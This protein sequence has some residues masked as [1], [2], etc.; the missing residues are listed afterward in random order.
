MKNLRD[1]LY[2]AGIEQVIGSTDLNIGNICNN[3]SS[4]SPGSLFVAIKGYKSDGHAFISEAIGRGAFAIVCS[5]LPDKIESK[6]TYVQVK[7]TNIALGIISS[8]F[9]DN[10]SSQLQLVGVTGTNGKTTIATLL[11]KLF[12]MMGNKCGLLS[13]VQIQ[14]GDNIIPATH[15]TPDAIAINML[16]RKMVDTGCTYCFME[17]S[18]HATAQHRISGLD[19]TGGV[20]SNIT[21]DHLDYHKTFQEYIRAKKLFFDNLPANAFSVVN[22]DDRN[23]SVMIQ[24]TRSKV[25]QYGIKSVADYKCKILEN[26]F[27]GLLLWLDGF[28]MHSILVGSFNASNLTAVYAV[29]TLLGADKMEVL[30]Y[31]SCITPVSGRF[32]YVISSNG[33][34]GIVDYAHTPDAL[35]NVLNTIRDIRTGNEQV[36]T[37]F[38]CG[39][40]RDNGKRP[41]MAKVACKLS[42]RVIITS[43]NPRSEDPD[44][45]IRQIKNGVPAEHFK[46]VHSITDRKE[47]IH[48]AISLSRPKDII[49]VAGKGHETY[50][51]I[52][53]IK[54]PFDDREILQETFK[55]HNI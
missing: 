6:V 44:E 46:K 45:I 30:K 3:S 7:N 47:A 22:A 48:M 39:G 20:F 37:V 27:E 12:S 38:G 53:G 21:H 33:I 1:I 14:I 28:E 5:E 17:V 52:R 55:I 13:T 31:L 26:N 36:I 16:L 11:Y 54:Y 35:E 4:V 23:A 42:D 24:S 25:Y 2:K 19:F 50:Q 41:L 18:S 51:E 49:L 34:I 29:A 43:D 10:P 40:D 9:Y 8:N 15:T 32:D